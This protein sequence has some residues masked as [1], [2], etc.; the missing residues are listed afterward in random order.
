MAR[1]RRLVLCAFLGIT[2][3]EL[4]NP[5]AYARILGMNS[6]GREILAAGEH[7][8][9]V[10]TSLSALAK[11]SA[12]AERLQDLKKEREIC[13]HWRLIKNS[14]AVPNLLQSRL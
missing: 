2:G 14:R 9:P 13:T 5:P 3:N 10:D 7:K 4:K 12:E 1:I 6:N 11:T 8:L